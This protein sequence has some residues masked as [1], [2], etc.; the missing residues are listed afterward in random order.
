MADSLC[1]QQDVTITFNPMTVITEANNLF[2]ISSLDKII[3]VTRSNFKDIISVMLMYFK[4][5][6]NV[7]PSYHVTGAEAVDFFLHI[8]EESQSNYNFVTKEQMMGLLETGDGLTNIV[9]NAMV[10]YKV[11]GLPYETDEVCKLMSKIAEIASIPK[12]ALTTENMQ[13]FFDTF[14][15]LFIRMTPYGIMPKMLTSLA[16]ASIFS[17]PTTSK[18]EEKKPSPINAL[19][20]T[21]ELPL[22]KKKKR[23]TVKPEQEFTLDNIFQNIMLSNYKHYL[24]CGG[25]YISARF[26][27]SLIDPK[28]YEKQLKDIPNSQLKLN[29]IK[30]AILKYVCQTYENDFKGI[31]KTRLT[32]NVTSTSS[33]SMENLVSHF[34]DPTLLPLK[35]R[36]LRDFEAKLSV[37]QANNPELRAYTKIESDIYPHL[38][39]FKRSRS[40]ALLNIYASTLGTVFSQLSKAR[41]GDDTTDDKTK[42]ANLGRELTTTIKTMTGVILQTPLLIDSCTSQAFLSKG[43]INVLISLLRKLN[44]N[45]GLSELAN[46]DTKQIVKKITIR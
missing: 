15:K 33:E 24:I 30:D 39:I 2:T 13:E 32:C 17:A 41:F 22:K 18:W 34:F 3:S 20:C 31:A 10:V 29:D 28:T 12:L 21:T 1:I 11:Y 14:T 7:D 36:V 35:M 43:N 4:P 40:F 45:G 38:F 8:F 27:Q 42:I 6:V 19:E 9:Y 46:M 16:F 44:T 25:D 5:I 37:L 23:K 26:Y